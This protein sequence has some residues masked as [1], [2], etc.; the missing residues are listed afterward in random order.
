MLDI[1]DAEL[2][3]HLPV[4]QEYD[5]GHQVRQRA[6]L[7]LSV[8]VQQSLGGNTKAENE[9]EE[10]HEEDDDLGDHPVEDHQLRPKVPVDV[11]DPEKPDVH[12]R[13]VDGKQNPGHLET[14]FAVNTLQYET[15]NCGEVDDEVELVPNTG[16]MISNLSGEHT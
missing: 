16:E 7:E 13:S 8:R 1:F 10:E 11:V 5:V 2:S 12:H 4:G 9:D 3:V 6:P 14:G 15:K